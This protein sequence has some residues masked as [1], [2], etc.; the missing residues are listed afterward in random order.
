MVPMLQSSSGHKYQ[1]NVF[2]R[3]TSVLCGVSL[4]GSLAASTKPCDGNDTET[5]TYVI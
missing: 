3:I 2:P 4:W 5:D 1:P